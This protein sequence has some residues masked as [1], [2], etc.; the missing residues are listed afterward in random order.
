[1]RTLFCAMLCL[2]LSCAL[3]EAQEMRNMSILTGAKTG[4]YYRFGTDIADLLRKECGAEIAVKESQ[5][6][7]ANLQRLRHEANS[8][9]AIV[10]QDSLDYLTKAAAS[11]PKLQEIARAI[12]LVFPLYSEEVHL[13]TTKATGIKRLKDI[14]GK[15]VAVGEAQSG[16]YLTSSSHMA[17]AVRSSGKSKPS[18]KVA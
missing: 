12:R 4:T 10:Q 14:A 16:T 1:M 7:L 5:G 15:R 8:Q 3:A 18:T 11:D 2:V 17:R 9:L 13:V 6:S